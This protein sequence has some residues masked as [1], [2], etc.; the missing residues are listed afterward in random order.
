MGVSTQSTW[1]IN[2]DLNNIN[3]IK[4]FA[5]HLAKMN[6]TLVFILLGLVTMVLS[7][8][9]EEDQTKELKEAVEGNSLEVERVQRAAEPGKKKKA[10]KQRKGKK[11]KK[12]RKMKKG[13]KAGRR[14]KKGNKKSRKAKK[15]QGKSKGKM[16]KG[17]DV[18]GKGARK[19]QNLLAK[20]E[21]EERSLC[22]RT[23]NS[24][25]LDTAVKLMKIV[26]SKITN[27]LVQ[28]KR[29]SKYNNTG[30]KKTAKKGLFGP[31][32]SKVIDVGGGNASDLSCSGNKT[33]PGATKLKS[34]ISSLQKC[35]VNIKAACDPSAYPL[36]N[37]TEANECKTLMVSMKASVEACLKKTGSEA[38]SCWLDSDLKATADKV[39]NCDISSSNKLV[40]A[41]HKQCTGNFS[42]CKKIED[43]AVTYIYACS[44]SA[45]TLKAKATQASKNVDALGAAKNKTSTLAGGSSGRSTIIRKR[46]TSVSTCADFVSLSASLLK[47]ADEAPTSSA[48]ETMANILK[49]VSDSLSCSTAEKS[50][51]TTQVT[52]YT[53]TVSK[54][55]AAYSGLKSSVEDASG[56]TSDAEIAAAGSTDS[57]DST[58]KTAAKRNRLVR[59]ILNNLN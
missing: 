46:A 16:K 39:K 48:V 29:I 32:A 6:K 59:D 15:K 36:P 53:Q 58:K 42:A 10:K 30:N 22:S 40:T 38:C 44:Q 52:T 4:H 26:N 17:K 55:S 21:G 11:A 18:K 41:Q 19:G 1:E 7:A 9:E 33:N 13:K 12:Q 27:F 24:T 54:V 23:V 28:Q 3:T 47:I 25:C 50:T 45:A 34:I 8:N 43:T 49:A 5:D 14:H 2:N 37:M 35:E 57:T 51:L 20:S 56:T 31:I